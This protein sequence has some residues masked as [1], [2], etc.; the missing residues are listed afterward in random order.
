M[1]VDV[2]TPSLRA[3]SNA[4]NARPA[5]LQVHAALE[6]REVE[7]AR[8]SGVGGVAAVEEGEAAAFGVDEVDAAGGAVLGGQCGEVEPDLRVPGAHEVAERVVAEQVG[9]LRAQPEGVEAERDAVAGV[10]DVVVHGRHDHRVAG[11]DL[12]FGDADDRVHAHT[13]EHE[14]VV[15]DL[16]AHAVIAFLR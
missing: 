14:D 15:V 2:V 16:T 8:D 3:S 7:L 11:R 12:Q 10:R 4:A 9:E 5:T 13:A 1:S 6:Q